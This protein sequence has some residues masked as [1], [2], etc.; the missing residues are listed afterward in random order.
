[1]PTYS[2]TAGDGCATG[3][4]SGVVI[5]SAPAGRDG[6]DGRNGSKVAAGGPPRRRGAA[7]HRVHD[8]HPDRLEEDGELG[9][10]ARR[11][12]ANVREHRH[13]RDAAVLDLLRAH[14]FSASVLPYRPIGSKLNSPG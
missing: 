12:G 13:H 2:E 5:I 3:A 14:A 1:M 9:T 6:R 10:L 8:D 4:T 11:L 7:V